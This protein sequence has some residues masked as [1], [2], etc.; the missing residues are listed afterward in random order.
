MK[1]K[2]MQCGGRQWLL[3]RAEL[4]GES[5]V[6][7]VSERDHW[8]IRPLKPSLQKTLA[9]FTADF[10]STGREQPDV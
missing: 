2:V 8:V 7:L 4:L 3:F 5:G 10:M 6:E 9:R 1:G